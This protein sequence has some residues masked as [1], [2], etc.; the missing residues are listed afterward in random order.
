MEKGA[1]FAA[2]AVDPVGYVHRS[3]RDCGAGYYC[4]CVA[5]E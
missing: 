3:A 1:V 2:R 5:L 4:A